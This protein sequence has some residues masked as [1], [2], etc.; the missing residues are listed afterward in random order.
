MASRQLEPGRPGFAQRQLGERLKL[1]D[2]LRGVRGRGV[3]A[4][5]PALNA[6]QDRRQPEHDEHHQIVAVAEVVAAGAA[7]VGGDLIVFAGDAER[8]EV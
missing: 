6:V 2:H 7:A 1:A 8:G 3:A 4:R 5:Q